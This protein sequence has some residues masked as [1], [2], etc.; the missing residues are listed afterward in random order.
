MASCTRVLAANVLS[1]CANLPTAGCDETL[2][3][4]NKADVS[5][6]TES[7]NVITGLTLLSGKTGYK[8]EGYNRSLNAGHD[9]EKTG[10]SSGYKH[11]VEFLLPQNNQAAKEQ[12]EAI[13]NGTFVCIIQ[14]NTADGLGDFEVYGRA[15]GLVIEEH[16]GEVNNAETGGNIRIKLMTH[17]QSREP[18]I[19]QQYLDTDFSTTKTEIVGL[20]AA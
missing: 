11:W 7:S 17:E 8:I 5:A 14:R 1:D 20:I 16:S 4:F 18:K 3:I 2:Y 6:W 10:F 19:P 13:K 9:L 12:A 15:S